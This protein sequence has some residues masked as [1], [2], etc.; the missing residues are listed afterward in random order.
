MKKRVIWLTGSMSSGKSTQRRLLCNEF[1][2]KNIKE[3]TGVENGLNYH[4]TSFG[5]I[6]CL[7]KVKQ[8]E[9]GEVSMCD[10]LDSIFGN[11][12]KDGGIF[13]IDKALQ[14]S[15]V[16][17]IEGSQTSPSWATL[18]QPIL[19]K[20]DADLYLIHL[21]MSYWQN[22]NRLIQRQ[23]EK[24]Q[25]KGEAIINE[26]TD[27]NIES[28]IGKNRQFNSCYDKVKGLCKRKKV[29]ALLPEGELF[30]QIVAFTF[31]DLY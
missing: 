30:E 29:N 10:G 23:N 19:D 28:L 6:S 12:K 21:E 3:H 9:N 11:V 17:V 16:V 8:V 13:S 24:L 25:A 27:R 7:G 22:F 18:M 14:K 15:K 4:F 26:L 20:H 5:I 31:S 1:A 2:T